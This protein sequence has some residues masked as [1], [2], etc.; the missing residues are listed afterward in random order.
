MTLEKAFTGQIGTSFAL[1][2]SGEPSLP[3]QALP[4]AVSARYGWERPKPQSRLHFRELELRQTNRLVPTVSFQVTSQQN[5][6][7][8]PVPRQPPS[9][10]VSPGYTP[11][12]PA[13]PVTSP[14]PVQR[15]PM[16]R[17]AEVKFMIRF[18]APANDVKGRSNFP[19]RCLHTPPTLTAYLLGIQ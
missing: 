13:P 15:P 10:P 3:A 19:I 6:S 4:V 5:W 18:P 1:G 2:D 9:G 14:S 11:D 12:K 8:A 17:E 16:Q 7:P